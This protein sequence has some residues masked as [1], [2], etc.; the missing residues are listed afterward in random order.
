MPGGPR[1]PS[2]HAGIPVPGGSAARSAAVAMPHL[3][4]LRARLVGLGCAPNML[5]TS[6]LDQLPG[7]FAR[8]HRGR[9]HYDVDEPGATLNKRR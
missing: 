2:T 9:W 4:V 7:T 8:E 5:P 1:G 6:P 3:Q